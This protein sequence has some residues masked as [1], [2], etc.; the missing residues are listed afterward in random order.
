VLYGAVTGALFGGIAGTL[1]GAVRGWCKVQG[2]AASP[3]LQSL[4]Q[5]RKAS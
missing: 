5:T 3:E 1:R 2:S 4:P